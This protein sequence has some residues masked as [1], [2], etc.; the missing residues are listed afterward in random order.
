MSYRNEDLDQYKTV[1]ARLTIPHPAFVEAAAELDEA[2]ESVGSQ[3][4]PTCLHIVGPSRAGKTR[5]IENFTR[6]YPKIVEGERTFIPVVHAAI[7]PKGTI[8]GVMESLL[9]ALGDPRWESG[10]SS[11]KLARVH[12]FLDKCGTRVLVLD[13]FQHLVDKGQ[14]STLKHTRDWAKALVEPRK[15]ALVACGTERSIEAIADDAQLSGRF[16]APIWIRRFDWRDEEL[17]DQFLGVLAAYGEALKPFQLPELTSEEM[18]IRMYMATGG[19]MG[20]LVK[21]L[22][23]VIRDAVRDER[24]DIGLSELRRAFRR[25]VNFSDRFAAGQGPFDVKLTT[26]DG[27]IQRLLAQSVALATAEAEAASNGGA[28]GGQPPQS[29]DGP[30]KKKGGG[31]RTKAVHREEMAE[32]L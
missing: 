16:D 11:N 9:R 6:K 24:T 10:S 5:L 22:T 27:G 7:P 14:D 13:E 23:R 2:L 20:T 19:L 4:F 18:V 30:K 1:M 21:L 8:M 15:F 28:E 29:E 3:S 31:R 17:H 25:A 32:A 26:L 12:N